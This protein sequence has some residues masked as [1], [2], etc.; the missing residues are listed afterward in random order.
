MSTFEKSTRNNSIH[1]VISNNYGK[2]N[3]LLNLV[4]DIVYWLNKWQSTIAVRLQ[5]CL[6]YQINECIILVFMLDLYW[7]Y[8]DIDQCR[9]IV[10]V[11]KML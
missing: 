5:I 1:E 6:F 11:G 2:E 3:N 9:I 4:I 8:G 10:G 7:F